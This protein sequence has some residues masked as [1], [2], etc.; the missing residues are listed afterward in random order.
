MRFRRAAAVAVGLTTLG[1]TTPATAQVESPKHDS[2]ER[3]VIRKLNWIRAQSGVRKLRASPGLAR[4]ADAQSTTIATTGIFA[5]GDVRGRVSRFVRAKSVGETL[6][7]VQ[8]AQASDVGAVVRSWMRSG[9]HRDALLSGQFARIGVARRSGRIGG[10]AA[11]V[12][13]VDLASAR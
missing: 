9:S 13:T 5:H 6:A 3:S 7:W 1:T 4:A 11:V 8:P 10:G 2:V 12:F